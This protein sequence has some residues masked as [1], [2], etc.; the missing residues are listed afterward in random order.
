METLELTEDQKEE[1]RKVMELMT[2]IWEQISEAVREACRQI[3]AVLEEFAQCIYELIVHARRTK[4][5]LILVDWGVGD[6]S[7]VWLADRCPE[8]F[9]PDLFD[10]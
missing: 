10:R 7:A 5:K 2:E 8:R 9:L 6:R 1:T 4:L 3:Q